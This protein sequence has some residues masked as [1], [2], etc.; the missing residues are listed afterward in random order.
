[1]DKIALHD[2]VEVEY[3]GKFADGF[4]FDT[5]DRETAQK[6]G[7]FSPQMKYK[8]AVVCIGENQLIAGLDQAL[9]NKEVSQSYTISLEPE[10]AFGKKDFKKIKLLPLEEFRKRN[11]NP[12]PGLQID[13]DGER[14]IIIKATGGRILINFNHPFAGKKVIYEIKINKKVTDK[15]AQLESFLELSLN[16]PDL[17]IEIIED[18][19]AI[20]LPLELPKP[21]QEELAK[22]IKKVISLKEITFKS[23]K[24]KTTQKQ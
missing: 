9:L 10:E 4:V 16:L 20:T 1:M 21:L 22:K 6:N 18:K 2:F 7:L 24:V 19:A 12:Q 15:K 23:E 13:L 5:T 11:I 17:K 14:G 3:T 8:P